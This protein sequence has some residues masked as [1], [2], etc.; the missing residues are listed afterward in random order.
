MLTRLVCA[1][2]LL[3]SLPLRAEVPKWQVTARVETQPLAAGD[4][5]W[6]SIDV[7]LPS[8]KLI[9]L[10]DG[11]GSV[12]AP[13]FELTLLGAAATQFKWARNTPGS[14]NLCT[15]TTEDVEGQILVRYPRA[16]ADPKQVRPNV[17]F[18]GV[19]RVRAGG[20]GGG[21]IA[22]WQTLLLVPPAAGG[23]SAAALA[24]GPGPSASSTPFAAA[25]PNGARP[26]VVGSAGAGAPSAR[27][28]WADSGNR[29]INPASGTGPTS[30]ASDRTSGAAASSAQA[31]TA[32]QA[33]AADEKAKSD[34]LN[35]GQSGDFA[36]ARE[37]EDAI[38]A[39]QVSA[40]VDRD[41]DAF[42]RVF[43]AR[44]NRPPSQ[45]ELAQFKQPSL[46][47]ALAALKQRKLLGV[48]P[49]DDNTPL[50]RIVEVLA[51]KEASANVD[52]NL[53]AFK[54]I[55]GARG[56]TPQEVD[57]FL[58]PGLADLL[59]TTRRVVLS[60]G[61]GF[62]EG[63][64]LG[65]ALAA[66][67]ANQRK[68][69]VDRDVEAFK[70]AAGW[71]GRTPKEIDRFLNPSIADL[72][73][74][75]RELML[76]T[77]AG[78]PAGSPLDNAIGAAIEAGQL[79]YVGPDPQGNTLPTGGVGATGGRGPRGTS[80]GSVSSAPVANN[81]LGAGR[82]GQPDFP[83]TSRGNTEGFADTSVAAGTGRTSGSGTGDAPEQNPQT[84]DD[85]DDSGSATPP[86]DSS[87]SAGFRPDS[88][89]TDV[90][91][92]VGDLAGKI[93]EKAGEAKGTGSGSG[94]GGE[95][96]GKRVFVTGGEVTMEDGTGRET[97]NAD[98]SVDATRSDGTVWHYERANDSTAR[99]TRTDPNGETTCVLNCG[100]DS[101]TSQTEDSDQEADEPA[102]A[103]TYTIPT[104]QDPGPFTAGSKNATPVAKQN[105]STFTNF[106]NGRLDSG[107]VRDAPF[108]GGPSTADPVESN[109]TVFAG[110]ASQ[111]NPKRDPQTLINPGRGDLDRGTDGST[112][113]GPGGQGGISTAQ[114]ASTGGSA[115]HGGSEVTSVGSSRR[116]L[117]ADRASVF[118]VGDIVAPVA[119]SAPLLSGPSS[120]ASKLVAV[121]AQ[122]LMVVLVPNRDGFVGVRSAKTSGWIRLEL[123]RRVAR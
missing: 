38:R 98:G 74:A 87:A 34:A 41:A 112:V 92:A 77:G 49:E 70:A 67:E 99:V 51:E 6:V 5:S 40:L 80:P 96:P 95:A 90:A 101:G 81:D 120:T 108:D 32:D 65:N 18:E 8:G 102:E 63:S 2:L 107:G 89:P 3:A 54:D 106:G 76:G 12:G 10:P 123:L 28:P 79:P 115:V 16:D 55:A 109:S 48:A 45:E 59:A 47:E 53:Q 103:D 35:A 78:S 37:R 52:R 11:S 60:N 25:A 110:T 68:A 104:D 26:P 111:L 19:L 69:L 61:E 33:P 84:P 116:I 31:A 85:D 91:T 23:N 56:R 97:V 1:G 27:G 44:N 100:E 39:D 71:R 14:Y 94:T 113:R 93:A 117:P 17:A 20:D 58:N 118:T 46:Y 22:P 50:D 13:Q 36:V 15:V 7:R 75:E 114:S 121:T 21:E 73:G 4:C 119:G 29:I 57:A 64:P 66:A 86:A 9:P 105:P 62:P 82:T 43:A 122:D 83:G 24:A 42:A 88:T 72:L 30:I